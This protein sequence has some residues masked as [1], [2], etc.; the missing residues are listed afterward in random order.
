MLYLNDHV[1]DIDIA[2]SLRAV[3]PQRRRETLLYRRDH[4]RR[5]SLAAYM[6]LQEALKAEYGITRP[7]EFIFGP[8]G[9]PLLEAYP[10]I[11]FSLSHCSRAALC[12]TDRRPV[13][14]DIETVPPTLDL[15][16]CRRVLSARELRHVLR[17]ASPP[18][19]FAAWW[20]RK[21]AFLK[22]TGEGLTD[23]LS[24]LLATPEARRA[25][26]RTSRTPDGTCVYT[27]C[28]F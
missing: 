11:H 14:C 12:V 24:T 13:G 7:P 17:S 22:L 19:A 21:E 10:H 2:A 26:F 8:H 6:L 5:L 16:L 4:D 20:T 27:V 9:K 18:H 15:G 23:T 3:S 28:T 25:T 1:G